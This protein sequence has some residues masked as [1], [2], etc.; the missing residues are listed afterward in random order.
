[1]KHARGI[2]HNTCARICGERLHQL[3]HSA[4]R[5][6]HSTLGCCISG[7]FVQCAVP[8]MM[9]GVD[10]LKSFANSIVAQV[11]TIPALKRQA[12]VTP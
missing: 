7:A 10:E 2:A 6:E 12:R 11:A 9:I 3:S 1:M 5:I 4:L 8:L